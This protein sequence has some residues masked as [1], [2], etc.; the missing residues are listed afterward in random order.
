M[1]NMVLGSAIASAGGTDRVKERDE[2]DQKYK[3]AT[4]TIFPSIEEW[5]KEFAKIEKIV[6]ELTAFKG[7]LNKGPAQLLK[8]LKL[9]DDTESRLDRVYVY[10][11]LLSDQDTRVGDMQGL[12]SRA[13]TLYINYSQAMS[14]FEPE[15]TAIPFETI[16]SWMKA[17]ADLDLYRQAFDDLYRQK[18]HILSPLPWGGC[19]D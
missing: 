13:R 9:R 15:M 10:A 5:D 12:S 16:D 2:I 17:D 7:T 8:V 14:W 19:N 1:A 4:E 6:P 3:W 18:K 11:S